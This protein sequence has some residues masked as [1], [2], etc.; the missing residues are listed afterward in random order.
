MYYIWRGVILKFGATK[1]K[2]VV[3]I[4]KQ[5]IRSLVFR[6][7]NVHFQLKFFELFFHAYSIFYAVF[8]QSSQA[9]KLEEDRNRTTNLFTHSTQLKR[10]NVLNWTVQRQN[11][12]NFLLY[13]KFFMFFPLKNKQRKRRHLKFYLLVKPL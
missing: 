7:R 1:F 9:S 12:Q 3:Y 11:L 6:P 10:C 4:F 8:D 2:I 13:K 5:V